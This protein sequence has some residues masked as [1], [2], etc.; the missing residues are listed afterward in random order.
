MMAFYFWEIFREI[1]LN[2]KN[3]LWW[4]L[5]SHLF[6]FFWFYHLATYEQLLWN[7]YRTDLHWNKKNNTVDIAPV[8]SQ[9]ELT[10]L[11]HTEKL[12]LRAR[13]SVSEI[14][15]PWVCVDTLLQ[16]ITLPDSNYLNG[17]YHHEAHWPICR[18]MQ[19]K[20][21]NKCTN[22]LPQAHTHSYCCIN[23][24][25]RAYCS[26]SCWNVPQLA[27]LK[28]QTMLCPCTRLP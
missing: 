17:N 20:H 26:L 1:S 21:T 2:N 22:T 9:C 24:L 12:M 13:D 19:S 7:W 3:N 14:F 28:Q 25:C 4:I 8:K 16:L 27:A 5:L 18:N 15:M 6:I 11:L 23:V 10:S